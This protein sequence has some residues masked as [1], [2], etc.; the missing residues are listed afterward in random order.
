MT[1]FCSGSPMAVRWKELRDFLGQKLP[2]LVGLDL[3]QEGIDEIRSVVE[4]PDCSR[5]GR[6]PGAYKA[7]QRVQA[8]ADE[9]IAGLRGR[10][11]SDLAA[12]RSTYEQSYDLAAL[13][14]ERRASF[15]RVFDTARGQLESMS[16]PLAIRSF[17]DTFKD[18]NA[19][20]LI[21]LLRKPAPEPAATGTSAE[22]P[23]E[24]G[25]ATAPA[26]E[27]PKPRQPRTVSVRRLDTSGFGRPVIGSAEDADEYLATLRA[28]II[29]ALDRGE[30]V[31]V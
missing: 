29:E 11:L 5:S 26:A 7:M 8:D 9:R 24:G 25:G 22:K 2:A 13:P 18:R 31:T 19:G 3:D 15:E 16:S 1:A 28:S 14:E 30:T 10:A 23:A 12:Y 4:D 20:A 27:P 21:A 17:V 6:L